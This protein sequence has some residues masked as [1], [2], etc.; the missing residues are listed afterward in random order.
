MTDLENLIEAILFYRGEPVTVAEL[1][2]AVGTTNEKIEE[3]LTGLSIRM[4]HGIRLVR[5]G[6]HAAL[7]T[8]PEV[9]DTIAKLR[10]EE[11]EGPL[12]KAGLETLAVVVYQG[13]VSRADIEYV[14]GVNCN[15]ILRSLTMRGLIERAENPN[16]GRGYV[17]RATVDLPAALGVPSLASMPVYD[18]MKAEI[19]AV[20]ASK[21]EILSD[22]DNQLTT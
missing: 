17:Y 7:A 13:P 8:S 21:E 3:A 16:D 5:E 15:A 12:G 6:K 22:P 19:A 1:S 2:K 4:T 11:L 18:E 9:A 10:K 14:R 20:V